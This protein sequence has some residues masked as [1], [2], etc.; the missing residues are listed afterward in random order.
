MIRYLC[1]GDDQEDLTEKVK[2]ELRHHGC[3][4]Y[5]CKVVPIAFGKRKNNKLEICVWCNQ[6]HEN[7]FEVKADE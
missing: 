7:I 6:G 5:T 4:T 2:S 3:S 1:W